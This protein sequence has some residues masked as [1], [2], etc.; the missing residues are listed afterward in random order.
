MDFSFPKR[1]RI[2]KRKEFQKIYAEGKR[3]SGKYLIIH[4]I[5]NELGHPRLGITVT[6]KCGKSVARNRWKRLIR[7]A[8]RLNKHRIPSWDIVV[9]VKRGYKPPKLKDVEED[10][11]EIVEKAH[12]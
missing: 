2:R 1:Y 8:F 10:L 3:V 7:E 4:F 11:L 6:K 9:T 5:P 12:N